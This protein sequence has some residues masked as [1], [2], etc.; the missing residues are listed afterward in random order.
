MRLALPSPKLVLIVIGAI[1]GVL[2]LAAVLFVAFFPKDYAIAEMERQVERA[3]ARDLSIGGAVDLSFWPALGFSAEQVSLTNPEGFPDEPFLNAER[4]VFAVAVM[5][6]LHGAVEVKSLILER[7]DIRLTAKPDG[8]ANWTFPEDP[9]AQQQAAL[10]DIKLDDVRLIDSRLSFQGA[11]GEPL[12]AE[13]ANAT[14]ALDSLDQP[15]TLKADFNYRGERVSLTADI[16]AP[17]ALMEQGET[18]LVATIAASPLEARFDGA[19]NSATG[20][21]AGRIDAEGASLRR[22]IAWT[23]EPMAAGGGFERFSVG[24]AMTQQ[25]KTTQLRDAVLKLDAIEARGSLDLVSLE[26]GRMRVDGALSIPS[27]DVNP[28]LPAP[29]QG[30]DASGVEVATAWTNDPLDLTGLK[31]FDA[32]LN[33]TVAALVFQK[34]NF[35]DV[36]MTLNVRNGAADAQL[37][38]FGFYN[39][40]GTARLVADGR[41]ATPR[42]AVEL[43]ARDV[44]AL[45]LLTDA[46]GLDKLEGRGRLTASLAGAGGDQAALMRSLAGSIAFNFNDGA[47]K[48]VNLAQVARTIQ[49]LQSGQRPSADAPREATDFAE[50][51]ANFTVANGIASTQDLRLLNP[52]VRIDGAGLIDIGAQSINLRLS[53]RAVNSIQGQGGEATLQGLG[54]PFKISGTWARPSFAVDLQDTVRNAVREQ[55]QRALRNADPN[56]PLGMLG[57]RIFGQGAAE[58]PAAE[59]QAPS[60]TPGTA[61]PSTRQPAQPP[62]NPLADIFRRATERAQ[63]QEEPAPAAEPTTP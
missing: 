45:G 40:T 61:P 47:W 24:A 32:N 38:R 25:D 5:P 62:S 14:L 48:G 15:A 4:I 12:V 21:L 28:Y 29:P 55:A 44:Q 2:V 26:A 34:L 52:Y 63:K 43:D 23:G 1:L 39:G 56:S 58:T 8:A 37:S 19:F 11:E 6:L 16:G 46:I 36:A 27:L 10:Q 22:L 33:L 60:E 20:A 57:A 50:I 30:G 13:G 59:E 42:I 9:S 35:S 17:R 53:P 7:A 41:N 49:S 51:A 54:V 31:A 3:T 18:P